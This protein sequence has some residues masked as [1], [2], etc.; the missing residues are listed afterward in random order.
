MAK[1]LIAQHED[2]NSI[3]GRYFGVEIFN[4]GNDNFFAVFHIQTY[5]GVKV[6]SK[7][8]SASVN[9]DAV[10]PHGARR[11]GRQRLNDFI[12]SITNLTPRSTT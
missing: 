2:T 7:W 1:T 10:A 11:E 12:A 6:A 8:A 4:D 9:L 5:D 3:D